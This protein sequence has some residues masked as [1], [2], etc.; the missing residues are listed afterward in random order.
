MPRLLQ[1]LAIV[2][3]FVPCLTPGLFAQ[4][5]KVARDLEIVSPTDRVDV[6]VQYKAQAYSAVAGTIG[7][8]HRNIPDLVGKKSL[9]F[10]NSEVASVRARDLA[11]L[12]DD[13]DVEFVRPDR[14]LS[15]TAFT[16][17]GITAG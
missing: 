8:K 5:P 3:L 9:R 7:S 1:K 10:L 6:I 4:H 2:S 14:R 11:A 17:S 12:A 15:T 13:P 16:G